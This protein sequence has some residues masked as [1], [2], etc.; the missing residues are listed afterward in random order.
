MLQDI[1]VPEGRTGV[2]ALDNGEATL[3]TAP[4]QAEVKRLRRS[5]EYTIYIFSVYKKPHFRQ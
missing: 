1:A 5:Q 2:L 4:T 3:P